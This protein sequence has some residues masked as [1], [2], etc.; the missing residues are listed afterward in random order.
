M[1]RQSLSKLETQNRDVLE[2][3][4]LDNVSVHG[5]TRSA[6]SIVRSISS[7]MKVRK[8]N[9][10]GGMRSGVSFEETSRDTVDE[11]VPASQHSGGCILLTSATR[12]FG[13]THIS[14]DPTLLRGDLRAGIVKPEE[15]RELQ[16][17]IITR[18][19]LDL[20]IWKARDDLQDRSA[21]ELKMQRADEIL[22]QIRSIIVS[23]DSPALFAT[24]MEYQLLQKI[25]TRM[26]APGKRIWHKQPPWTSG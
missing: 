13:E 20:Q 6:R 21:I 2:R 22:G 24:E 18:A 14:N 26:D 10:R 25:K 23:M 15:L 3:I 9:A 12:A 11:A 5:S 19:E 7:Q 16:E 8:G 17:L 1:L 4:S